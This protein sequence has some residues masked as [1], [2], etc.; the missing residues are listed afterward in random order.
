MNNKEF[1]NTKGLGTNICFAWLAWLAG[2]QFV[3]T[4]FG[5]V[6]NRLRN[7]RL[8]WDEKIYKAKFGTGLSLK[9]LIRRELLLDTKL[10][11]L[12]RTSEG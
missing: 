11:V 10:V 2:S 7:L 12:V 5:K 8:I 9:A 1:L 6:I 3:K 4:L